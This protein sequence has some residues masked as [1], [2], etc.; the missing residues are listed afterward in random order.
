ML[1]LPLLTCAPGLP[2]AYD[3][4]ACLGWQTIFIRNIG[5]ELAFCIKAWLRDM[6][7]VV[8]YISI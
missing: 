1:L 8:V 3:I 5:D 4:I 2:E 7:N 6:M